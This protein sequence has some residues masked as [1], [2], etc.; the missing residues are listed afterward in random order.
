MKNKRACIIL[1]IISIVSTIFSYCDWRYQ[2]EILDSINLTLEDFIFQK[3]QSLDERKI[4]IIG[5]DEE[6]L[7]SI[8]PLPWERSVYGDLIYMLNADPENAPAV[9]GIDVLFAGNKEEEEDNYLV[10]AASLKDNLVLASMATFTSAIE[11][12]SDGTFTVN[13]YT[14]DTYEEPYEELKEVTDCGFIN[15]MIGNDGIIR[16][17]ILHIKLPDGKLLNSFSYQIYRKYAKKMGLSVDLE[18]KITM[19]SRY[20]WYVPFSG[21]PGSYEMISAATILS[22]EVEPSEFKDCI[23]L[24]GVYAEGLQDSY[25]TAIDHSV[26]MNGIEIHANIIQAML[27]GNFKHYAKDGVQFLLLGIVLILCSIAFQH[28]KLRVSIPLGIFVI[29]AYLGVVALCNSKN[30]L[31]K[32]LY[33]PLFVTVLMIVNIGMKYVKAAIEKRKT[34][35][36]F[37][38]YVAPQVVDEILK[39]GQDKLELGGK[40][41]D[42]ACLFVDIRGFTPMSEILTP[43]QVVDVLNTYL[44][45]TN[46]CIMKN[47]GTLDKFIGDA[48]MAIYNA[49]LPLED[50]I[51]KAV[52]SAWDMVQGAQALGT[53]LKK[54]YGREVA[55]GIGVHCGKAVVGNIGTKM[56][57]D[58]TAI[59]DTVNTAA[60]LEANAKPGEILISRAVYDALKDRIKVTSYGTSIKL[61]GKSEGFEIFR[62]D[63]LL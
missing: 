3:P 7:D 26:K 32:V 19:N 2:W 33:I 47:E 41:T 45:L 54:K 42:I 48:T 35:G 57:M 29:A 15:N 63:Q 61:K 60:R 13:D 25:I 17:S 58:Y 36:I 22:G 38:S 8:G 6:S 40:M 18:D 53:D 24:I 16:N 37:K 28:I 44:C 51:Y 55:F 52:K 21:V 30:V 56:R 14:I 49:P 5:I 31:L 23:V 62:V 50:Y 34:V 9:I 46:E 39:T 27:D 12:S 10:E 11:T 20:Q 43:H 4:V 1:I 59:G